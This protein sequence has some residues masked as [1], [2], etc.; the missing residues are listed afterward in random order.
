[1]TYRPTI[2]TSAMPTGAGSIMFS[3]CPSVRACVSA[4]VHPSRLVTIG[5]RSFVSAGP[6]LWNSLSDDVTA[7]SSL[8]EF[9]R[10]LILFLQ[11]YLGVIL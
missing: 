9:R 4:S 2:Y 1:M 8:L 3:D 11:S 5:Y 10:N 6:R 7:A